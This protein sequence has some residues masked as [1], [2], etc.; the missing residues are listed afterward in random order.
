M[1]IREEATG[2]SFCPG[3]KRNSARQ[4]ARRQS[5]DCFPTA[6]SLA[7]G[8]HTRTPP[9]CHGRGLANPQETFFGG[10]GGGFRP[11]IVDRLAYTDLTTDCTDWA[12]Q[13]IALSAIADQADNST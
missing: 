11:G 12:V 7:S 5:P 4:F 1:A 2:F 9:D 8:L 13:K 10:E 3:E 6:K